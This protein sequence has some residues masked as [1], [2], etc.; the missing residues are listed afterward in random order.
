MNDIAR[1][2]QIPELP[3]TTGPWART[4]E[5]NG[6]IFISGLRGLT[7][8]TGKPADTLAERISLIFEHLGIIL[9]RHG[10][11]FDRVLSSRVYVT[12][13]DAIRPG[14]NTAFETHFGANVPTRTIVE[15]AGLNQDDD[16]E[17]EFVAARRA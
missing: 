4:V 15:V 5:W 8:E 6:L 10:S 11:G 7:M 12:D 13:M 9:A 3:T 2:L 16:V 14:V 1:T 17:I